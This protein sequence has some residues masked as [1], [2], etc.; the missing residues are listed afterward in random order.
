MKHNQKRNRTIAYIGMFTALAI[1]LGY[2]ELLIPFSFGIPG[3]KLGLANIMTVIVLYLLGTKEATAVSLIR[4]VVV[5][6]LFGGL[7]GMLYSMAG[8]ILSLV[9]MALLKKTDRFSIMGI[10]M[11]GGIMHNVGQMIIAIFVV[12]ELRL[13]YYLPVLLFSGVITGLINGIIS[14]KVCRR[15]SLFFT[16]RECISAIGE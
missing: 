5:N 8:G 12:E 2:L 7:Y 6:L 4:I 15:L 10:S 1:I 16:K 11:V 3:V 9:C 13:I 14:M